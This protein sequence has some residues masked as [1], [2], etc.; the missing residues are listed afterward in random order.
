MT[1]DLDLDALLVAARRAAAAGAAIV[2]DAFGDASN[3]RDEGSRRLGERR[4]HVE[5][6]RR[7]ATLLHD[8]APELAFFGEETGGDRA[9]D[10]GWFVDPLDGTANFVHGF[11]VVGV[12]VGA[13]RRRQPGGGRGPGAA[14]SVGVYAARL[15]G[16][17]TC[18]DATDPRQRP[19]PG[20]GDLR[21]RVPVP[22]Q[23]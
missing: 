3:V 11:P 15:G 20:G 12:S 13:G 1:V 4:R 18:N 9:A 14:C 6:A 19:R 16:G 8:A 23:A 10:V 17:A 5:R 7:S 21:H 22:G 2:L